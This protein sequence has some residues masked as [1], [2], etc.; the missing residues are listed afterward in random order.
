LLP[1]TLPVLPVEK[2][3][4]YNQ[5]IGIEGVPGENHEMGVLPPYFADMHGWEEMVKTVADVYN[6]LPNAEK[7]NCVIY[8]RNYGEAGAIDLLG[9]KYGL[10]GA[11]CAHN[12]YWYWGPP[13]WDGKTA[14]IFGWSHSLE[15]N[16]QDLESRFENVNLAATFTNPYCMP[17]ESNLQIFTCRNANFDFE[18]IW[19]HDKHF[20]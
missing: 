4:A 8:V 18:E 7:K 11:T 2:T 16:L 13:E 10:P 19:Q 5:K 6:S 15:D 9:K 1:V 17:Y 14:I 3:I 12:N 20:V